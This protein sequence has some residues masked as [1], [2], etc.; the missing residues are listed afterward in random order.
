[1]AAICLGIPALTMTAAFFNAYSDFEQFFCQRVNPELERP[2]FYIENRACNL[3]LG[4][5]WI[6]FL[7]PMLIVSAPV[8]LVLLFRAMLRAVRW[9]NQR[10]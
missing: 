3:K 2:L 6:W 7:R 10:V 9:L 4:P 5:L 8:L 1:M